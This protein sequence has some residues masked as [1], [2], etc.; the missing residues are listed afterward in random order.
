M[1]LTP[2]S[3][4]F[5]ILNLTASTNYSVSIY[6]ITDEYLNENR[7]HDVSQLPNKL[8]P[9]KWLPNTSLQFTT[10]GCEP[11]SEI[12]TLQAS[13]K[14]IKLSWKLPKAF[15]STKYLGQRLR[16]KLEHSGAE[17]CMELDCA[18]MKETIPGI[19]PSGSYKISLDSVFSRKISLEDDNDQSSWKEFRL[20]T[21]GK[22]V[23]VHFRISAACEQPELY[24]T[25]FTAKTI[26]LKWNKPN[27]F[28]EIDHPEKINEKIKTQLRLIGYRVYIN[29]QK[30]SI[31][32]QNQ[33][34]C[35][36]TECQL[37]EQDYVQLVAQ[38]VI[39]NVYT[40]NKVM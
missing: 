37:G 6:G 11:A 26:D 29:E 19:L 14:S 16:W 31:L 39:Q 36:L 40:N 15:G 38:T 33:N 25:G 21:K 5:T 24:L 13:T 22:T 32:D 4:E 35:T 23:A 9:S 3:T 1:D 28:H 20:T 8:K 27:M 17:N 10:S 34:Q 2:D 7:C 18:R 12:Q 30:H